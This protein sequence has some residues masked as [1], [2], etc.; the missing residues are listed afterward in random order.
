MPDGPDE[1]VVSGGVVSATATVHVRAAGVLSM[2]PAASIARTRK[3]WLPAAS[4]EYPFG[5]VQ[6]T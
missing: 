3:V 1:I 6:E 4:A 5:E 2:F